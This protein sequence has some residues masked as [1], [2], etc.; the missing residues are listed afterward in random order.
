MISPSNEI[1]RRAMVEQ[2]LIARGIKNEAVLNAFLNVPREKF[3]LPEFAMD[4]YQDNP[5]P[6][7]CG[8]TISQPY[9]AA[10]M[11]ELIYKDPPMKVLDVGTGSGYQTAILAFL[12][13][14]V[15][16][17]EKI[18]EVADFAK[19][20]LEDLPYS[21]KI[22]II[23]SDGSIGYEE[24]A[25]YDAIIVSGACP[26]IPKPLL[27]QLA[28]NAKLCLPVGHLQLQKLIVAEKD[29]SGKNITITESIMCR[30][31]PLIGK[32][33]FKSVE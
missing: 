16:S 26:K 32:N 1:Q 24:E 13:F 12:G 18:K 27:S 11:T 22:K 15:I 7:I 9:M 21:D 10:L 29:K 2:Q 19:K 17:I 6:I 5:L 28:P 30:F 14:E 23:V 4:A 20:N 33:A 8:Q 25:P 3:V 31:V